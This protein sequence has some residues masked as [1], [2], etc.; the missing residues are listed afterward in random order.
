MQPA[1]VMWWSLSQQRVDYYLCSCETLLAQ[2]GSASLQMKYLVAGK[3]SY[4]S[5]RFLDTHE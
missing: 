4:N 1:L 5:P 3:K 2:G